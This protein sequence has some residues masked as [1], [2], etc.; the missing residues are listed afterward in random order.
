M[1]EHERAPQAR[2]PCGQTSTAFTNLSKKHS[3]KENLVGY[4][5]IKTVIC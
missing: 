2:A 4:G 3:A 5:W 1:P